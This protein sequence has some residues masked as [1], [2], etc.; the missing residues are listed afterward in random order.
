MSKLREL[1]EAKKAYAERQDIREAEIIAELGEAAKLLIEIGELKEERKLLLAEM[2]L[3]ILRKTNELNRTGKPM[4]KTSQAAYVKSKIREE[5]KALN[6]EFE[7]EV[8]RMVHSGMSPAE[9]AKEAGLKHTSMV[10]PILKSEPSSVYQSTLANASAKTENGET[11]LY[12]ENRGAHR[13]AFSPDFT[14]LK[15]HGDES[16]V[17]LTWPDK[18]FVNGDIELLDEV[19]DKRAN[20]ALE[21]LKGTYRGPNFDEPNPYKED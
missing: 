9:V 6:S 5:K 12:V 18:T 1:Y 14:V 8:I 2:D 10:Y 4:N 20:T 16:V 3:K 11:F 19:V 17:F 7:D 15:Y 21:I 13:Y